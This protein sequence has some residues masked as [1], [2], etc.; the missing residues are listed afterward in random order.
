MNVMS[1]LI[2]RQ[3]AIDAVLDAI[4]DDEYWKEQVERAISALPSAHP[5]TETDLIELEDRF[6]K[7]VRYVV[8]DM[9]SGKE[10]R[11]KT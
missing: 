4:Y 6:G 1:D 10:E 5:I 11:W 7:Y 2:D 9:I 8:E 3:A